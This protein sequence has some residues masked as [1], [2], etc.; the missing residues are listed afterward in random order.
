MR[1][2]DFAPSQRRSIDIAFLTTRA[3]GY[4]CDVCVIPVFARRLFRPH[5]AVEGHRRRRLAANGRSV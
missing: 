3:A 2:D 1:A 4:E 5:V